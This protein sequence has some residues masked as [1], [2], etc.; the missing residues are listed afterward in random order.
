MFCKAAGMPEQTGKTFEQFVRFVEPVSIDGDM[1]VPLPELNGFFSNLRKALQY[2]DPRLLFEKRGLRVRHVADI[3]EFVE[4]PEYMG[5]KAHVRPRIMQELIRLFAT[6]QYVEAVLCLAE[7]TPV[8]LLDGTMPTIK[9]L[10]ETRANDEFWVYSHD[11]YGFVPGKARLPHKTGRDVLWRVT[12]T[13]GTFVE[14]NARHQFITTFGEKVMI[15]DLKPGDRLISMYA[16]V[17]KLG[18]RGQEYLR[19]VHPQAGGRGKFIHRQVLEYT[20]GI[21]RRPGWLCHHKNFKS[22]D[23]QPENLEWRTK[24]D[25]DRLHHDLAV[26]NITAYNSRPHAERRKI[27]KENGRK[28]KKR[29]DDPAQRVAAAERMRIRNLAGNASFAARLFWDSEEGAIEKGRRAD[30]MT[31]MNRARSNHVVE[32]VECLGVEVDVYCL[33]VPATGVFFIQ[34]RGKSKFRLNCVL[35]SNTGGIGIGKNYMADLAIGYMVYRLSCFHNPQ[36]EYDLAP[37]SNIVFVMQSMKVQLAQKV[38]FEQFGARLSAS[39]YFR[40]FFPYDAMLKTEMRFPNQILVLPVGGQDTAAI[41]MNVFGGLIDEMNFMARTMGSKHVQYTH[42]A[43]F[44]QAERL[45]TTLIRRMKSRFMQLGKLPGKLLLISSVN[46]PGDFTDRKIEEAK[47]D[48]TIFVMKLAQW[49]SIPASKYCGDKFLV[50]VGNEVKMSRIITSREDAIDEQDVIEVPVE[51]RPDFE[52]DVVAALRDLAG[53]STGSAHPFIPFRH[54]IQ[55][56]QDDFAAMT[57]GSQLFTMES[58]VLSRVVGDP[59]SP[60]WEN[61]VAEEYLEEFVMGRDQVFA[62]HLDVGITQDAAGLALGRIV[63][64]KLLPAAKLWD[65]RVGAFVEVRD[66]R[67]PVYQIDGL[68]QIMPP[69]GGEV[70]LELVR[71]LLLYL[72]SRLNLGWVS[73]DTYQ[74]AMM[75][76]GLRRLRVRA[77]VLS[78]DQTM[79][80]Y[81]E[82]KQSIKDG[83]IMLPPHSIAARE[84]REVEKT[85]R[86]KIDHPQGGSKDCSDGLAGVVYILGRKE[87]RYGRPGVRRK[88]GLAGGVDEDAVRHVRIS[89]GRR[90]L[91]R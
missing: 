35:S 89:S 81:A 10:A 65:E 51:Y 8:P 15:K 17:R 70:D 2:H 85:K 39:P 33:N 83:R 46:Y 37:G 50:E 55:K 79:G 26:Q 86:E 14:G 11:G 21:E 77:G 48:K 84:L 52:R 29:W 60:E 75:I 49:E 78:V 23:N 9:E 22:L 32:K 57:G 18:L 54:L 41:G 16:E 13:D 28:G 43:E 67:A 6:D 34:A 25:H 30:R 31:E 82:L 74:S 3:Q 38:V 27:A 53:I 80:P 61:I 40:K 72:H 4:S 7:D 76:Q 36:A 90:R 66:L 63:G 69:P 59:Y 68:L 12:F 71:D 5:Q 87:A 64:Y 88:P 24:A 42:E 73:M 56:A 91:W 45:Y 58:C 19:E 20:T 44:D 62:A 47:K 1:M